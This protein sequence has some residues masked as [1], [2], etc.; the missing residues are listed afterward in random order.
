VKPRHFARFLSPVPSFLPPLS[1]RLSLNYL[2]TS[3]GKFSSVVSEKNL[4]T[5]AYP[6]DSWLSSSTLLPLAALP[7]LRGLGAQ[8][9]QPSSFPGNVLGNDGYH[10]AQ[11]L[12]CHSC[13]CCRLCKRATSERAKTIDHFR[14]PPPL[15]LFLSLVMGLTSSSSLPSDAGS[16]LPAR[17]DRL[18]FWRTLLPSPLRPASSV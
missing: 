18:R 13:T 12:H 8:S 7:D 4:T 17:R 11:S 2:P 3:K 14:S 10:S 1:R 6:I 16:R 15:I 9:K 5:T